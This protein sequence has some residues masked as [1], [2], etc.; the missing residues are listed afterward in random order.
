[1]KSRK[2]ELWIIGSIGTGL[3]AF[4]FWWIYFKETNPATGKFI[5]ALP[6]L[7]C[8]LNSLT[9]VFLL[10]GY[11]AI[12]RG[13]SELHKKLMIS[14]L[15]TSF[16]FFTSYLTYHHFHGDTP[17][18]GVGIIRIIY[19]TLLISHIVGS[20]IQVPLIL[21]TFW[22]AFKKCW[23]WHKKLARITFPLWLFVSVTGVLVFAFLYL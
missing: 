17:F 22:F 19:F 10:W 7:N 18:R 21:A 9:T 15:I 12:K 3:L 20:L 14:A 8:F 13:K 2:V 23:V 6:Y 4:T 5:S 1:M 11:G 16:F